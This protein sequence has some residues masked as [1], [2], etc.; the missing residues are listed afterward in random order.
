MTFTITSIPAAT[1]LRKPALL[2]SDNE[3]SDLESQR[4]YKRPKTIITPGE[5][6]TEDPKWMRYTPTSTPVNHCPTYGS[7]THHNPPLV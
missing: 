1:P 3:D 5:V 6:V 2:S 7:P 4:P